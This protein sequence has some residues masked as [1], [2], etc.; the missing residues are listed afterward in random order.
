MP[1]HPHQA[2]ASFVQIDAEIL[3]VCPTLHWSHGS[4]GSPLPQNA[5]CVGPA[6]HRLSPACWWCCCTGMCHGAEQW[7]MS[8]QEEKQED[9]S[10][11]MRRFL[12]SLWDQHISVTVWRRGVV[13]KAMVSLT[14][15]GC[16]LFSFLFMSVIMMKPS[17]F[18][19]HFVWA[20]EGCMENN[21]SYSALF[22]YLFINSCFWGKHQHLILL[23][24]NLCEVFLS[25]WSKLLPPTPVI[26]QGCSGFV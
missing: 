24:E 6:W 9:Y 23:E 14:G 10:T 13:F 2:A 26:D 22:I 5:P 4:R 21:S 7:F 11:K 12:I 3:Q 20:L 25:I 1:I 18:V 16:S 8:L 15:S 17:D 19:L